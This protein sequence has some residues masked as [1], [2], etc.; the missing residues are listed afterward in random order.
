MPY[1]AS[2]EI[3]RAFA[4]TSPRLT[5]IAQGAVLNTLV[6]VHLGLVERLL[7]S[8]AGDIYPTPGPSAVI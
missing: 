2:Y 1:A 7:T 5:I 3:A 8:Y 6:L 4:G